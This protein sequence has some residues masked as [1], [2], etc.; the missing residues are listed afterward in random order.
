MPLTVR[1]AITQSK[2]CAACGAERPEQ[3]WIQVDVMH[4]NMGRR[5][6]YWLQVWQG[7]LGWEATVGGPDGARVVCS[8]CIEQRERKVAMGRAKGGAA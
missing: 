7:S 8:T 4:V 5:P 6:H 2:C 1:Q 3:G